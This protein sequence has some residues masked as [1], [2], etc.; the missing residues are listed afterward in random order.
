MTPAQLLKT[1]Q[2]EQLAQLRAE[3][4]D[5]SLLQV[6]GEISEVDETLE[7]EQQ[8]VE[9]SRRYMY[10]QE[11][12]GSTADVA[13]ATGVLMLQEKEN[14]V[15]YLRLKKLVLR[16]RLADLDPVQQVSKKRPAAS[17]RASEGASA[18]AS[19]PT[20]S[21]AASAGDGVFATDGR[22]ARA[23][24]SRAGTTEAPL[25]APGVARG[26]R[27]RPR[28]ELSASRLPCGPGIYLQTRGR[29]A[30]TT[31]SR[32]WMGGGCRW[33]H[34]LMQSSDS[35]R[36]RICKYFTQTDQRH[37]SSCNISGSHVRSWTPG[38][39]FI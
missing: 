6:P 10:D 38:T 35:W 16:R 30:F 18:P 12:S 15:C 9:A 2:Q 31:C 36:Y 3:V 8:Q 21:A 20:D 23:R 17:D 25:S 11:S 22:R 34:S 28:T 37:S 7:S 26:P 14:L 27:R 39:M 24:R 1:S 29:S 5:M 19:E 4:D 32:F 33:A 13:I